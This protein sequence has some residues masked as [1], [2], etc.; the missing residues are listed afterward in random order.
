MHQDVVD[1]PLS[2]EVVE[3]L[4]RACQQLL[5][6]LGDELL[7]LGLGLRLEEPLGDLSLVGNGSHPALLRVVEVDAAG[8]P[9]AARLG[10]RPNTPGYTMGSSRNKRYTMRHLYS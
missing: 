9:I 2:Q 5:L 10:L 8:A 6:G 7:D 3:R 1:E 4:I